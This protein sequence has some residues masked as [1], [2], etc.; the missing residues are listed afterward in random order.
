MV[1]REGI[2]TSS[3]A[4]RRLSSPLRRWTRFLALGTA[5]S[6]G[7]MGT[8]QAHAHLKTASPPVDGVVDAAPAEVTVTFTEKLEAQLSRLEVKD[9]GGRTVS[10]DDLHLGIGSEGKTLAVTVPPLPAGTYMVQWTAASVDTHKTTGSFS[11]V[12]KPR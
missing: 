7:S 10:K 6:L 5:L 2:R 1:I 9:S 3:Q 4:A 11:F 12:V 8:A